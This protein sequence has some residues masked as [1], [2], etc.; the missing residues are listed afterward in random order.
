MNYTCPCCGYMTFDE[1]PGSFQMCEICKWLDDMYQLLYLGT[2]GG[3]NEVSLIQAQSNYRDTG[4]A[5]GRC[6]RKS[7]AEEA[8]K[9]FA[10]DP[11]W[12]PYSEKRDVIFTE[13][14]RYMRP[15]GTLTDEER[16]S[17]YYWHRNYGLE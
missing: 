8:K 13:N 5:T 10:K 15:L 12:R 17:L 11:S 6:E 14:M 7:E 16:V 1:P 3:D 4:C 2:S 9:R